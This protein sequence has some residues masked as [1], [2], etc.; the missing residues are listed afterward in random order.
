[1][2][3]ASYPKARAVIEGLARNGDP[4]QK[5]MAEAQQRI[6]DRDADREKARQNPQSGQQPVQ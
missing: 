4:L 2:R 6:M 3:Y 5:A 1:M